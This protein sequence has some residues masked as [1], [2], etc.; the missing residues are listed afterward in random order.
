MLATF[1]RAARFQVP[2]GYLPVPFSRVTLQPT[3]GMPFKAWPRHDGG[4]I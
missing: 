4:S 1:I 2:A 3:G